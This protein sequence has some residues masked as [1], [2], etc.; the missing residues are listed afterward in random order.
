M[1]EA[2]RV[3]ISGCSAGGL[4]TF[5]HADYIGEQLRTKHAPKLAKFGAA[6]V[7]GYF[8]MAPNA[9]GEPA[10][11]PAMRQVWDRAN[12]SASVN[13]A[14]VEAHQATGDQ[15]KCIGAPATFPHIKV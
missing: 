9:A 12:A 15:W 13:T 3:L 2:E 1:V 14:C 5:L 11:A 7:S 8:L 4:A 10:Y 6:P